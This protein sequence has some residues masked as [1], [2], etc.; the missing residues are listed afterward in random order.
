MPKRLGSSSCASTEAQDSHK[1]LKKVRNTN[2]GERNMLIGLSE[3]AMDKNVRNTNRG[4][5]NMLIGL[6]ELDKR[7]KI[8]M[9]AKSFSF[10]VC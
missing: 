6:S 8:I 5:R 1:T 4:E 9:T 3:A 2:R 7:F 10:F